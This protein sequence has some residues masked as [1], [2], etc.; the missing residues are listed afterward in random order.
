MDLYPLQEEADRARHLLA[1]V[2]VDAQETPGKWAQTDD[3][4]DAVV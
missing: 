2:Q 4:W 3:C 1:L